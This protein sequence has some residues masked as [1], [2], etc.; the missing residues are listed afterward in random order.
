[1]KPSVRLHS[2]RRMRWLLMS[3]DAWVGL[4]G[5]ERRAPNRCATWRGDWNGVRPTACARRRYA[6]WRDAGDAGEARTATSAKPP[7]GWIATPF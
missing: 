5:A 6:G 7:V 2:T 1:M 4:E 3:C